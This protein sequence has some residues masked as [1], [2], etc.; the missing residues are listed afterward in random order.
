MKIEEL[1]MTISISK[2]R[3]FKNLVFILLSAFIIG[4]CAVGTTKLEISHNE[5]NKVSNKKEG[6]LLVKPFSDSRKDTK[7]I[8]NK[9]NLYGM[10][11]GHIGSNSNENIESILTKYFAEAL[12]ESGYKV[13]VLNSTSEKYIPI[14]KYDAIIEGDILEFWMD[15]Y[16]AVWHKITVDI[17]A[18]NPNTEK[19]LWQNQIA[20]GEKRVLWVGSTGEFERIVREAITNTLNTALEKFTSNDFYNSINTQ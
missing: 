11:L 18:T 12:Q 19:V 9:R 3:N 13:T 14:E 4:G 17:K 1:K 6:N 10:V 5:L 7:Y 20:G 2:T 15:L 16:V 8:G